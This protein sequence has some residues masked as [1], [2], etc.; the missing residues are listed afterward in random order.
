MSKC[1]C[2]C[3]EEVDQSKSRGERKLFFSDKC[4][5]KYNS[6][7]RK[8]SVTKDSNAIIKPIIR[9]PGAKWS[10]ADWIIKHLPTFRMYVEPYFGSGAIFF[11][12]LEA[13]EYAVLNDKSR[14]VVNLF[15]MIRTRGPE[16]CAQVELTPW[17][18]DEYDAA[19]Q[20]T[21]DPLEDARC[22]L[23]RCWQAHGTRLNA[24]T[25][26]RN[27]GSADGGLTYS[28]W[29]Q[30]PD[31]IAAVIEKLKYAEIENR[32]ALEIIERYSDDEHCLM[33]VDPPY[34]MAT[35]TGPLYEHEMAKDSEHIALLDALCKHVGPVVLSGYAH[36]LYDE[37][38]KDWQRVTK[39]SAVEKGQ[40]RI[41]VLW[42]NAK[43]KRNQ[44]SHKAVSLFDEVV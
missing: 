22:F 11:S 20:L 38:L 42:L 19:Y 12:L 3:M 25:G 6:N 31:R 15:E 35:R 2:G 27:R 36:P 30:V 33:Y 40:T 37:R 21:G 28:L 4:R 9:Y 8:L 29:N 14:S 7:K 1:L 5:V 39:Q 10:R 44:V 43:A 17:A 32:D 34:M 26:W 41:E 18:R 16:L 23:V 13:P 24:K